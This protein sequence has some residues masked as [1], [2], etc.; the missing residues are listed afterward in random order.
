LI[1]VHQFYKV[2]V[3]LASYTMRSST[4]IISCFLVLLVTV[5]NVVNAVDTR[6]SRHQHIFTDS[7][8]RNDEYDMMALD[9]STPFGTPYGG[10]SRAT[11]SRLA[12]LPLTLP[13]IGKEVGDG[14]G[15]GDSGESESEFEPMYT[16]VRDMYGRP[17]VCRVYHEDELEPSSLGDS[18]FDTPRLKQKITSTS[19]DDE[20]TN[21]NDDA[22][23]DES[24]SAS[25][26]TD[27]TESERDLTTTTNSDNSEVPVSVDEEMTKDQKAINNLNDAIA[28]ADADA[29]T[30]DS[31]N[32]NTNTNTN[33]KPVV[34]KTTRT[35]ASEL[36]PI[37]LGHEIHQR[38]SKL[39]GLC[40][41]YH[42][43]WWSYEWC[44]QEKVTQ[45]HVSINKNKKQ[46]GGNNKDKVQDFKLEDVTSLG[47]YSRRTIELS[48]EKA[49]KDDNDDDD[50][51]TQQPIDLTQGERNELGRV[52]D[53]FIGGDMCPNTGQPRVTEATFR[54]CSEKYI[55][56]SK[57][58]ILKNGRPVET[59]IVTI[60]EAN[61][62]SEAVCHYNVTLCTPLL[63]DDYINDEAD[64]STDDDDND[65]NDAVGSSKTTG[66]N[67]KYAKAISPI[68]LN[69]D[70]VEAEKMSVVEILEKTFGTDGDF[71]IRSALGGWW[72]YEICPGKHV[73]QYHESEVPSITRTMAQKSKV[74]TEHFLGR[75]DPDDHQSVT[76][77]NEWENVVNATTTKT[78]SGSGKSRLLKVLNKEKSRI[79]TTRAGGNGSFYSQEYTK[80]D[81]CD[82]EDVTDSAI[83][84]GEFGEGGIERATTVRYSCNSEL[85]ISVK[86]DSTC[87]YIVEISVP[88]L[89]Y[90]PLFKAPVSKKQVVKC[91]P[92]TSS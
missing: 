66:N 39:V 83:K 71:C 1:I 21:T 55:A 13:S 48:T 20:S 77:E 23:N 68:N 92:V 31:H 30:F 89:C 19:S 82:H 34:K 73:R 87:H 2:A 64:S 24:A 47:S 42:P 90:H 35:L 5:K 27:V 40:A 56:R 54:C 74:E 22:D 18:M 10:F 4:V 37:M 53:T 65:D 57:G 41:Q 26:T 17:F 25:T 46:G 58:G 75:F 44:Y 3:L 51:T 28:I 7:F 79:T 78:T 62:W 15:A 80:G 52:V 69:L 60:L 45:F 16:T 76:K 91:L 84:A 88:T 61:E 63:C 32:T 11:A 8:P 14:A 49:T 50:T 33:I 86:E 43:G 6:D 36:N 12:S 67:N 38:F 70:P 85:D 29:D 81:V 9:P 72:T 59:D